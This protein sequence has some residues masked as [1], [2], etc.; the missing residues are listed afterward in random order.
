MIK[1]VEVKVTVYF[2]EDTKKFT[3]SKIDY[4][5]LFG[6]IHN[7]SWKERL[8]QEYR[9]YYCDEEE[10]VISIGCQE[11]LDVALAPFDPTD[12]RF[13]ISNSIFKLCVA[14]NTSE[15]SDILKVHSSSLDL[16]NTDKKARSFISGDLS[17]V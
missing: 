2:Q 10:D 13:S 6:K 16:M 7:A 11:D 12:S 1:G 15:A 17:P 8:L 4:A 3:L 5:E 14:K 9:F